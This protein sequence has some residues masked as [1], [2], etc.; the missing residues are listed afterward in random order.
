MVGIGESSV[1]SEP[2]AHRWSHQCS[3][4]VKGRVCSSAKLWEMLLEPGQAQQ[5]SDTRVT[6]P[7]PIQDVTACWK[8]GTC[9]PC[10]PSASDHLDFYC[11]SRLK[12]LGICHSSSKGHLCRE[13]SLM[14]PGPTA[15]FVRS[16]LGTLR[17][18]KLGGAAE[19]GGR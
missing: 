10:S 7:S 5:V 12:V 13:L 15:D 2:C 8:A 19:L 18:R 4:S 1:S 16:T 17:Q 6:A 14:D 9:F 3:G 11:L